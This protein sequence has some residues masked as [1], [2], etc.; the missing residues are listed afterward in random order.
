MKTIESLA[1]NLATSINKTAPNSSSIAVLKYALFNM[2]NLGIYMGIVLIIGLITGHFLDAL[3][4]IF[5][6]PILR[7]FSGGLHFKSANTCNIISSLLVLL[8]I[9]LPISYWYNGFTLNIIAAV[10]ILINAPANVQKSK[11]DKKYYPFLKFI[12]VLIVCTNFIFQ[13]HILSMVF[14]FQSLT[15]LRIFQKIL[16]EYKI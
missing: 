6:F 8:S 1:E 5:A 14:L 15:T 16:N 12:A 4:V 11:L 3:M 7:Y 9:Y 10:I 13:S 2:L